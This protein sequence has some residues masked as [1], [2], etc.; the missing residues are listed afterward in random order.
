[1]RITVMGAGGVG[2]Y[3]GGRLA[4]AGH[5]VSFIARGKHLETMKTKG[6]V[7]KSPLGDAAIEV[8]ASDKPA[9]LG[10]AEVVL[11][12]VKLWDTESAAE[13]I[14]PLVE[15]GGVVI[16]FQNGVESIERIGNVLGPE[17]VLGGAAIISA[18][19][20]E[21]G[22]IVQVGTMARLRFGPT[23]PAQQ[24]VAEKFRDACRQSKIDVELTNDIERV[25]WEKFV[26][27]VALSAT[28]AVARQP[29]GV[30]R[31][32]PDL[33]WLLETVMRETWAVGR[34][35]GVKLA[36]DFVAQMMKFTD[37]LPVEMLA[38]MAADLAAGGRLEVPWLSG[39]VARMSREAGLE[40]P[41]NRAVFAALKP[42]MDGKT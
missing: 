30:V 5:D 19:I 38:S 23:L 40:A 35:R 9:E 10:A 6:L 20:A 2:G 8:T 26:A 3:F 1:M 25:L 24:K 31:A 27:I 18:R 12:A 28:T 17:R 33:R 41:A 15:K 42:Y 21:P 4:Q 34:K 36:D 22:V 13:A 29:I 11:F 39:A 14:R 7:L 32:D 37:G 16:P